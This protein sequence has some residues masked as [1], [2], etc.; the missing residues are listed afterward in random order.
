MSFKTVKKQNAEK[1]IKTFQQWINSNIPEYVQY[2]IKVNQI[3]QWTDIDK[4]NK[5][6]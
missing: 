3:S 2:E 6:F 5:Y 1:I 4:K